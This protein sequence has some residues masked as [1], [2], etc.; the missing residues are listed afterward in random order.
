MSVIYLR[1]AHFGI[2]GSLARFHLDYCLDAVL[3]SRA[4][5]I[6]EGGFAIDGEA[7]DFKFMKLAVGLGGDVK[8]DGEVTA[9]PREGHGLELDRC[10][11]VTVIIT[12]IITSKYL[13]FK[14]SR[15]SVAVLSI[16]S[17]VR[18]S[19]SFGDGGRYS[20][21]LGELFLGVATKWWSILSGGVLCFPLDRIF[22]DT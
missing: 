15:T 3:L 7:A 10:F 8:V 11:K 1:T 17:F 18:F 20:L 19:H 6:A 14:V 2:I 16:P 4:N 22:P 5:D 12:H 13:V 9:E 21:Q